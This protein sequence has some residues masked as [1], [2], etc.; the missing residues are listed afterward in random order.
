MNARTAH[1]ALNAY[2]ARARSRRISSAV[3]RVADA[4]MAAGGLLITNTL[5]PLGFNLPAGKIGLS[6][7]G[8]LVAAGVAWM[9]RPVRPAR[10]PVTVEPVAFIDRPLATVTPINARRV[11][12]A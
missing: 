3:D 5:L 12:A 7:G 11:H 2:E 1:T 9:K 10:I 8:A 4:A 6:A